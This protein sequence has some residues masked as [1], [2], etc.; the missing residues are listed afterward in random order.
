MG[1]P[2]DVVV[3]LL[4]RCVTSSAPCIARCL[5]INCRSAKHSNFE[6]FQVQA[7]AVE[8]PERAKTQEPVNV[9]LDEGGSACRA[10]C[11]A[12]LSPTCVPC[13]II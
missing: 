9:Q 11:A 7:R 8:S 10:F 12:S 5:A 4:G 6:R 3:R 1:P 13:I 2:A